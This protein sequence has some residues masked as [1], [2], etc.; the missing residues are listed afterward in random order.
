MDKALKELIDAA[1]DMLDTLE[2]QL[3]DDAKENK[4]TRAAQARLRKA[5]RAAK[6]VKKS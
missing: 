5:I 4:S 3:T 1:I 2:E 6:Q